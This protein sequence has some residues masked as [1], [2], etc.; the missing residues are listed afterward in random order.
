VRWPFS[1]QPRHALVQTYSVNVADQVKR[2]ATYIERILK[3][4]K[5]GE[6]PVQA[7]IKFDLV[8]LKTANILGLSVPPALLATADEP[9]E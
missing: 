7:P 6:L 2:S 9:I 8:N 4:A 1:A 5:A 3:G